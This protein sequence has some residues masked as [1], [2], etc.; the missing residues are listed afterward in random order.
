MRG[1]TSKIRFNLR[2]C[3]VMHVEVPEKVEKAVFT[4][5]VAL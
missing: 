4:T 2:G 1:K 5:V 3:A